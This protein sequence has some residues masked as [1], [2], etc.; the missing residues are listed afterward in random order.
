M[1][2]EKDEYPGY[3]HK[4]SPCDVRLFKTVTFK[5]QFDPLILTM[6]ISLIGIKCCTFV[7]SYMMHILKEFSSHL[8][9][10]FHFSFKT[11]IK[12]SLL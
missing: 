9:L 8:L 3:G 10:C 5:S 7:M 2:P 1:V 4:D 11:Q 12:L 6:E